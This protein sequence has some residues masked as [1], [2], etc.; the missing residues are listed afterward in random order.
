MTQL[1]LMLIFLSPLS[2]CTTANSKSMPYNLLT[3]RAKQGDKDF[4]FSFY[5]ISRQGFSKT[6]VEKF[7]GTKLHEPL[8][9]VDCQIIP[10]THFDKGSVFA[11]RYLIYE[12]ADRYRFYYL[13]QT[14]L[15]LLITTCYSTL[16]LWNKTISGLVLLCAQKLDQGCLHSKT[17]RKFKII[18]EHLRR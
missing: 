5:L 8:L 10:C 14:N 17:K 7:S 2:H 16:H 9:Q 6:K 11:W 12:A 15:M 13:G 4:S 18:K 3:S 1:L